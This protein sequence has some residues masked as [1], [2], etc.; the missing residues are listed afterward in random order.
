MTPKPVVLVLNS[1]SSSLKYQLI[2]PDSGESLADGTVEQ[3]GEPGSPVADHAA[4]L[5]AAFEKLSDD[6]IDLKT[7]G[8]AA[9]GHRVVHGG[10]AFY[11]PTVITDTVLAELEKVS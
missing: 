5:Q 7:C 1:G 10:P 2:E 6:G 11:R 4:A 8:L 3:I 9:V